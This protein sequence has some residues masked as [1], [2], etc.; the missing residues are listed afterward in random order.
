MNFDFVLN[1]YRRVFGTRSDRELKRIRPI[2][3][4]INAYESEMQKL[5]DEELRGYTAKFKEQVAQGKSLEDIL[6]EAFAV[7]REAGKRTM[8]MRHYDVQMMGGIVLNQNMVAEMRTGE[9][10]TLVATLPVYLN[11]LSGKGVHVITVNDY[12]AERDARWMSNIYNFL[13]LEVGCVLTTERN[14]ALK[15]VAYNK[16]IT[17]GTNNEFGFDYLRDNMKFNADDFVQ[18]GHNFAIIDE[19]DSILIDE[20]RTPLIISGVANSDIERYSIVDSAIPQ[21]RRDV[22]YILDEKSRNIMLTDAGVDRVEKSLGVEN[23][24]NEHNVDILHHVN[25][26]MKAH[27]LFKRDINY[28]VKEGEVQII[29]ENTGRLMPGRRWSDGL[30]QAIEAKEKVEIQPESQ[31]YASITYQNYFRMYSKLSGM[32]GTAETEEEEFRKIY[33][34]DVVVVPTNK[35]IARIDHDDIIYKT[36]GEKFKAVM[37][38]LVARHEKGQ[39]I[40][41]G[42][43]SVEKSRLVSQLLQQRGIEHTVL[44]AKNHGNEAKIVALAGRLGSVTV[45]TNMA[46]RGT[47]IKLGGDPEMMAQMECPTDDPN[48]PEVFARYKAQ[49]DEEKAKVLAAGGLHILGTERHESRRI[50]NQLRGRSGRQ[51]DPGSSIFFLCLEDDLLRIF[52]SDKLIG[53]MEAMGMDDNE[54]IEHRWV[55]KQ[56]EGAQKKVEAQNFNMRK[57]LLEYDDVMNL[58]RSTVYELRKRV[59]ESDDVSDIIRKSVEE[60]VED[61]MSESVDVTVHAEEWFVD[62]LKEHCQRVFGMEWTVTDTEIRDMAVDEIRDTILTFAEEKY[63]QQESLLGTDTLRELEKKLL[64][65][66]TDQF[67]K[68]HLLAMD[69]LRHG[70][71]LRGYGQQNPLLEYKREGTEMF[72]LM[73][74]LRDEAVIK[75]IFRFTSEMLMPAINASRQA[76]ENMLEASK[77]QENSDAQDEMPQFPLKLSAITDQ[78]KPQVPT[79]PTAGAEA[80]LFGVRNGIDKNAPCPCGSEQKFKKCCRKAEVDPNELALA[81][82]EAAERKAAMAALIAEREAAMRQ[83]EEEARQQREAQANPVSDER[84]D[85]TDDTS[86]SEEPSAIDLATEDV[87]EGLFAMD[88]DNDVDVEGVVEAAVEDAPQVSSP[89]V[90]LQEESDPR[91]ET[92]NHEENEVVADIE[93]PVDEGDLLSDSTTNDSSEGSADASESSEDPFFRDFSK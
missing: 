91:A 59:L 2:V 12:L 72:M 73:C 53:W 70:V 58:Q 11:A 85:T 15:K 37:T 56:I 81:K 43:T 41:V 52:S 69:R 42:T 40:L 57:N 82:E 46:G 38:D 18:R 17:Y 63:Q 4:R 29:D 35:P 48:Y 71:S 47:D 93:N 68:D 23:L 9:G 83:A 33:N 60:L 90:S 64:L 3:Q 55:T 1:T 45:S 6:P 32:T 28:V 61:I 86:V 44:N 25:Q 80:R 39:P 22:D 89:D 8:N 19:V 74:S 16:D 87:P 5:S 20:A 14:A 84:P 92:V 79:N 77:R 76:T 24:Y 88:T 27:L 66:F 30:H 54:P 50:D 62:D 21:L 26:A 7:V 67:W 65:H 78:M 31:T 75:E 36:V 10:K 34:L 49:C 51:G 13:G